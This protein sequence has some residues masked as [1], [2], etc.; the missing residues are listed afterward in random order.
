VA[1][2]IG[3]WFAAPYKNVCATTRTMILVALGLEWTNLRR[4]RR[5]TIP[6]QV[7]ARAA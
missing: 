1:R 5:A 4:L 2:R 7:R 3:I 6:A